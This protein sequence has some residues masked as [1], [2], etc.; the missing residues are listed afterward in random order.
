MSY[1]SSS[2]APTPP[3]ASPAP[4]LPS[5]DL[6]LVASLSAPSTEPALRATTALQ[7]VEPLSRLLLASPGSDTT[8]TKL[9]LAGFATAYPF[10]FRYACQ[11]G[12]Q[13][14]WSRVV[15]LKTAV[16]HLWRNGGMGAKVA[17]VKV[18]Q[19]IIQTQT[20]G[21]TADP[22]LARTAEPNLSLCRPNHPFLKIA[23]LEDE[24]NKLLEECITTLF[25]S[26]SPDLVSAL[27]SSL[28]TLVKA[29]PAFINLVVT[30]LTNWTPAALAGQGF[31]Q[32]K[33][34]EKVVR[35]SLTHLLKC[36]AFPLSRLS[37]LPHPS[38]PDAPSRRRNSLANA[39]QP[40]ITQFLAQ[41]ATRMDLA[42]LDARKKREE[43]AS[44]KRQ[45]LS[46]QID[47]HATKRRRLNPGVDL[48]RAFGAANPNPAALATVPSATDAQLDTA[49]DVLLTVYQSLSDQA[50]KAAIEAVRNQLPASEVAASSA[51]EAPKEE[52]AYVVDPLKLDL[53]DDELNIKAEVPPEPIPEE[54]EPL[55]PENHAIAFNL[56]VSSV[57]EELSAPLELTL[58]ARHAMIFSTLKRICAAGTSGVSSAVWIPLVSRLITRGLESALEEGEGEEVD[59]EAITRGERLRQVLFAYVTA[60][61]P[62]RGRR[63]PSIAS[64]RRMELARLWLNEEWY[65]SIRRKQTQNRPYDRWLRRLLEHVCTHSSNADKALYQ[66]MMDLP[67]IPADEMSRLESMCLN[68]DQMQL[69]FST[70]REL[71]ILRPS[72]R[73]AALDVLLGLT[74]HAGTSE[75][76]AATEPVTDG[77]LIVPTDK[78]VRNAAIMSV[79]KW[80]PDVKELSTLIVEFAL[81]LLARLKVAVPKSEEDAGE[82]AGEAKKEEDHEGEAEMAMD[83]TPPP[84]EEKPPFAKVRDGKVVDR[85]EPPKT[86]GEVV[87]HVELLL[88]L[89]VKDPELLVPLFGE[90][91]HLQPFPRE[92]LEELIV[93]LVRS[94]GIKHPGLLHILGSFPAGSD[95]LVLKTLEI[96]A[97]KQKL[98]TNIIALLKGVAAERDLDS[99]FYML[100]MPECNKVSRPFRLPSHPNYRSNDRLAG[101]RTQGEIIRYLPR[102]ISLLDNTPVQK[103]AIRS[104]FLSIIAPPAHFSSINSLRT[105]SDSLTPVELMVFLHKHD[106]EIGVKNAIEAIAICFSMADAFRPEILAAFMQQ[107]VDEPVLPNLFLR[108]V[109]QAV[110]TYKSLQPFVSTTLLSRLIAKKVWTVGPLWEGFIR[111]AKVIAPSSF[112]AL[113]QLPKE[114]LS[115]LVRKQPSMRAP[116]REYVLKKGGTNNARS[117][118]I[119]EAIGEDADEPT[120]P[121]SASGASSASPA[122]PPVDADMR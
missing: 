82:A 72:V 58:P 32:I 93:P 122:P 24:A 121:V 116:L 81:S 100:I 66:F 57:D 75:S 2:P 84:E 52:V 18:I 36:V 88:A 117:A 109:I 34:V 3:A 115:D 112:A 49:V 27:A 63:S 79:K 113:L 51:E 1:Y 74:T 56:S 94:L 29:R 55:E 22:R 110:T 20:T 19:R 76:L 13:L 78:R 102:V 83:E 28:T 37:R 67:E 4:A 53:G 101:P 10:L 73:R 99:R 104:I 47:E 45:L 60:D 68:P 98:P 87:Q 42:A 33:S 61:L 41:Q 35:I 96:L 65:A 14:W 89:C 21:G 39:F 15:S 103:A 44:K 30:A 62:P 16:L 50:L 54:P 5:S 118:T 64:C 92:A 59:E 108:T 111:C 77:T 97:N 40:Q 95:A 71:A 31:T 7:A 11:S 43:D 80:V 90:F 38:P 119:L 12:D 91:P 106:R 86:V 25:T 23:Q 46:T 120:Q 114:Q 69:G 8:S 105:R 9:A 17:A 107:V 26:P 6:D 70:L 48:L 85:L